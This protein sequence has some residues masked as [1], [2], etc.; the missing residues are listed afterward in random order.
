LREDA[1]AKPNGGAGEARRG[2]PGDDGGGEPR[3]QDAGVLA[4]IG[5]QPVVYEVI[6]PVSLVP[7]EAGIERNIVKP[8]VSVWRDSSPRTST[9]ETEAGSWSSCA[10]AAVKVTLKKTD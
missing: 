6:P 8:T 7:D 10:N 4:E 9:L 2:R 5:G 1:P 3:K